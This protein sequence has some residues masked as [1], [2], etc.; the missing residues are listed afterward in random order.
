MNVKISCFVCH[1][2]YDVPVNEERYK[3]WKQGDSRLSDALP[4]LSDDEVQLL[5]GHNCRSCYNKLFELDV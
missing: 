1:T 5:A 4:E 3:E 2:E